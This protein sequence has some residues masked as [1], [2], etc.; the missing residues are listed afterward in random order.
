MTVWLSREAIQSKKHFAQKFAPKLIF[1]I[2]LKSKAY[3][4]R[5]R[6]ADSCTNVGRFHS[7]ILALV[8]TGKVVVVGVKHPVR[9]GLRSAREV[10][11]KLPGGIGGIKGLGPAT[12]LVKCSIGANVGVVEADVVDTLGC[13]SIDT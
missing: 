9:L 3:S 13:N 6:V 4:F 10:N 12:D 2:E 7:L 8:A 11:L 1:S 5:R